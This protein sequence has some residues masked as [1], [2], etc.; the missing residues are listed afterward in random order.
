MEKKDEQRIS[1][2]REALRAPG[3]HL[4]GTEAD[5][6]LEA[7]LQLHIAFN[8]QVESYYKAGRTPIEYI[9]EIEVQ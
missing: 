7:E 5:E 4:E 3:E 1:N 6:R 8:R 9:E 2:T